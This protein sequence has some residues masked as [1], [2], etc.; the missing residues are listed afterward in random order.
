MLALV[1]Q[2]APVINHA[3][4]GTFFGSLQRILGNAL[5][6]AVARMYET[7]R[8][9]P[10]RSIPAALRHLEAHHDVLQITDR[11]ALVHAI[12]LFGETPEETELEDS[13]D[14]ALTL[15]ATRTLRRRY[16]A[17]QS[18]AG[19]AV[20]GLRDKIIAHHEF[21]EEAALPKATYADID[22]LIEFAKEVVV[23][24]GHGY[25]NVVY[26]TDDGMYSL[27]GDAERATLCL[28]RLLLAAGVPLPAGPPSVR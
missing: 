7:E 6:L 3:T 18:I 20:K 2:H 19:A 28:R 13:S 17:L 11:R 22:E 9:Y 4:F 25:T 12:R 10:L 26:R 16:H 1:G 21:V 14:G 15:A 8:R 5:I 24:V 27:A 23:M